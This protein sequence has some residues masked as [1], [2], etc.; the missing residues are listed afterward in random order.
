ML[1]RCFQMDMLLNLPIID[2]VV[3]KNYPNIKIDYKIIS[4]GMY[5]DASNTVSYQD[6]KNMHEQILNLLYERTGI[7]INRR[8][9]KVHFILPD[10]MRAL[11]HFLRLLSDMEPININELYDL[12]ESLELD[13]IKDE[14]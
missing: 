9:D 11:N 12:E 3:K 4:N 2:E 8:K 14:R 6:S 10:S 13:T 7:I 5:I 1:K